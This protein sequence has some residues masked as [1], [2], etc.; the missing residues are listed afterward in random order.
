MSEVPTRTIDRPRLL[1]FL[2]LAVV[3]VVY[4]SVA[5]AFSRYHAF[6]SGDSGARFA[7]IANWLDYGSLTRWHYANAAVD[8][9][10][11]LCALSLYAVP[12]PRGFF[13]IYGPLF[14]LL[15][16]LLYRAFGFGGLLVLPVLGGLGTVGVMCAMARR[17]GLRC[18]PVL[19][20]A[21]GLAT[22]L[23]VYSVVFWDHSLLMLLAAGTGWG[24]LRFAETGRLRFAIVSGA[25]L[26]AGVWLHDL[27]LML[28]FAVAVTGWGLD[29]SFRGLR[30][31]RGLLAG[32]VPLLA[33]WLVG[34]QWFYGTPVG[35]HLAGGAHLVSQGQA[36]SVWRLLDPTEFARRAMLQLVGMETPGPPELLLIVLLAGVAFAGH[37]GETAR[38]RAPAF[39]AAA[40][41]LAMVLVRPAV[42][43]SG[44]F[45]CTPLLIP[46]LVAPWFVSRWTV[47][48]GGV[49]YAW[50]ARVCG[51]F[52]LL[53]L[54]NPVKP[55]M[56]WGSRYLLTV[57]PF[58]ALLSA[59][60][61][62]QWREF[63]PASWRRP[64]LAGVAALVGLSVFCQTCG[65][66]AVRDDLAYS[67]LLN[68]RAQA[69]ASPVLVT[70]VF[71][72]GAELTPSRL[73]QAQFL[74][75]TDEE[76][77]LLAS[78]LDI[79]KPA[80][81]AYMGSA[82]GLAA[83]TPS[84]SRDYAPVKVWADIG[85]QFAVFQRSSR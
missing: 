69:L 59:R 25:M 64:A 85:L 26:G 13:I 24:M 22:P 71:W 16:G 55:G 76:R 58:L 67:R 45:V 5:C 35:P 39:C 74:F 18:W 80:T 47:G 36:F 14:P 38:W 57:L 20:L 2:S 84:V 23:V 7:M 43:S 62:E 40:A 41:V 52:S 34:N 21:L 4:V 3:A 1:F 65:L 61:L 49:F 81:F 19:P 68:Q 17:L 48:P 82:E 60:A 6:W 79:Q 63:A 30:F 15:S 32:F 66:S 56:D 29:G 51:V 8:P 72:L 10:G 33:L 78:A 11:R 46:A 83:L 70:D 12:G 31:L 44:L 54:V 28:F 27:F 42:P 77:R 9:Q 75:H 73:S 53:V 50:S 37:W